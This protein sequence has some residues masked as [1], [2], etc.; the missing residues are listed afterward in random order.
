MGHNSVGYLEIFSVDMDSSLM[1]EKCTEVISS[2]VR[3]NTGLAY[4]VSTLVRIFLYSIYRSIQYIVCIVYS[5]LY[6][7]YSMYSVYS[8]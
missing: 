2:Q 7:V 8:I 6:T 1:N 5:I 4:F 3:V